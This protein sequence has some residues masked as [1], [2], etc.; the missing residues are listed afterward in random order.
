MTEVFSLIVT[1]RRV[2]CVVGRIDDPA[3]P[4]GGEV[5]WNGRRL[6][7]V[8][9]QRENGEDLVWFIYGDIAL[10][11]PETLSRA[12]QWAEST[13]RRQRPTLH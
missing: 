7:L 6:R 8:H 5:A 1:P 13:R 12:A 10:S 3:D 2:E 4:E 9:E 11:K